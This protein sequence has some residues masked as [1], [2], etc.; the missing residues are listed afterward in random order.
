MTLLNIN[1]LH[2]TAY[3]HESI[4][5]L[6]NSHKALGAF[7]RIQ[8]QSH[9]AAWSTWLPYWRFSYNTLVQ[10]ATIILLSN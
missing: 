1:Q 7:L 4:G 2:S 10:S 3:H 6:E 5:A 9:E 8:T